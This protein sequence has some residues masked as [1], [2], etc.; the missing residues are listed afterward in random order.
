MSWWINGDRVD[1]RGTLG[2]TV[3]EEARMS[4]SLGGD[5]YITPEYLAPLPQVFN[6]NTYIHVWIK[7]KIYIVTQF[8]KDP[9][10][11]PIR[12]SSF[13]DKKDTTVPN[14]YHVKAFPPN[15]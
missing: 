15:V 2:M 10:D 7:P 9:D 5:R 14:I 11:K 12:F 13:H 4:G 1:V 8:G 6:T 3:L